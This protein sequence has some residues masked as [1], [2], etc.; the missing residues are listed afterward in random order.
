VTYNV[1]TR[2]KAVLINALIGLLVTV[3]CSP[4]EGGG[5]HKVKLREGAKIRA[6]WHCATAARNEAVC[7]ENDR[8][9]STTLLSG[10]ISVALRP[11][12]HSRTGSQSCMRTRVGCRPIEAAVS[13][14]AESFRMAKAVLP[15]A[16]WSLA[17]NPAPGEG[18][19]PGS[20]VSRDTGESGRGGGTWLEQ[21]GAVGGPAVC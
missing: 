15:S 14:S 5:E 1:I 18:E 19:P 12:C 10:S 11:K 9:Y 21:Y 2:I 7:S 6:P 16:V 4:S 8:S 17:R 20:S 3:I 13:R